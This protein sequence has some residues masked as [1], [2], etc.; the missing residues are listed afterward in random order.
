F[1]SRDPVVLSIGSMHA[2]DSA[3]VI[4]ET[5]RIEGTLRTLT[6]ETR[7]RL[8]PLMRKITAGICMSHD[9][10]FE[11]EI[12]H[13]APSVVNDPRVIEVLGEAGRAVLG[14][15]GIYEIPLPSM[16][17]EDFSYYLEHIPGAMFRLGTAGPGP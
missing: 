12:E 10:R 11:L 14:E 3:N 17:G 7:R 5:A 4:P 16:G 2:G 8:E 6:R 1:D 9:A 13:G 15:E